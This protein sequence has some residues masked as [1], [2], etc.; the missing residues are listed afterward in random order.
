[1]TRD[2]KYMRAALEQAQLAAQEGEVPVGAVVVYQD[3]VIATGRSGEK[4]PCATRS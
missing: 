2:E 4:T 1:M 3:E